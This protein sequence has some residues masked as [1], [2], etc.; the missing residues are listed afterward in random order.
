MV[1]IGL[2]VTGW[3]LLVVGIAGLA[4]PGIQGIL[5]IALA[6]AVLSLASDTVHRL[7]RTLLGRWPRLW[8]RLEKLRRRVHGKLHRGNQPPD[9]DPED[10]PRSP[11]G[12]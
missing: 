8:R 11:T 7:L 10:Q 5:T 9:D 6:A 3:V 1:R 12:R 2:H 4:L